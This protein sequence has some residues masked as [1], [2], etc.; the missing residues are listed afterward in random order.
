MNSPIGQNWSNCGLEYMSIREG[1]GSRRVNLSRSSHT[2]GITTEIRVTRYNNFKLR[3]YTSRRPRRVLSSN[4]SSIS[5]SERDIRSYAKR[6]LI[7]LQCGGD[8]EEIVK[9]LDLAAKLISV[10]QE[11]MRGARAKKELC[12]G[13]AKRPKK[14]FMYGPKYMNLYKGEVEEMFQQGENDAGNKL[15][16]AR[17]LE[18]KQPSIV[19]KSKGNKSRKVTAKPSPRPKPALRARATV[20]LSPKQGI[21]SLSAQAEKNTSDHPLKVVARTYEGSEPV[22][23]CMTT[24][25]LVEAIGPDTYMPSKSMKSLT[26]RRIQDTQYGE[27]GD[28]DPGAEC[29]HFLFTNIFSRSRLR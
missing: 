24:V 6:C 22:R 10:A 26:A 8:Y 21:Q 28:W 2:T 7:G 13:W 29:R 1:P 19:K 23:E 20:K 15:G 27:S 4:P 14:G 25:T 5:C 11:C 16:P 9:P 18:Q 17:M 3:P 12:R